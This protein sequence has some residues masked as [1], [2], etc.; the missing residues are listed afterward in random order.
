MNKRPSRTP[1]QEEADRQLYIANT[2]RLAAIIQPL[3][4]AKYEC[5]SDW[6]YINRQLINWAED[7]GGMDL[8][9]DFQRGH[10]WTKEQQLHFIENCLRGV[11]S[12][13]GFVI[14]LNCP[15]WDAGDNVKT[16]LPLGFQCIDGLQRLTAVQE[17]LKGNVKPFGFTP[18]DLHYSSFMIKTSFRFRVAV[19][20]FTKKVDLLN[21]YLAINTGGTPHSSSEIERVKALR[22][23]VNGK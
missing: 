1:E 11:V 14:Q 22:D 6:T 23:S 8:C 15:N 9:P 3:A 20:T 4:T 2:K 16:D 10:V 12:S 18:D 17:F 5:D 19:H 13:S 21:H 7:Y